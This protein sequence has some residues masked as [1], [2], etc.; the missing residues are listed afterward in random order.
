MSVPGPNT[1]G[2]NPGQNLPLA[3]SI[4][5]DLTAG[6]VVF[7]VAIPLCLGI[8]LA[9]GA[10]LQSGLLS[11]IIGGIVVGA[12]SGSH[13]SVSGPA[14]GLAAIVLAQIQGLGSFQAFLAAVFLAGVLQVVFGLVK[15]GRL[16]NFFPNSVVRGLLAAIGV[17][18]ILKQFPHLIGHDKDFEGEMSFAQPDG[19]NTFSAIGTALRSL[20]PGATLIGLV[21]LALLV[22]WDRT[23]LKKTI[24]PSA[25]VAVLV[26]TVINEILGAT[27]SDWLV[28]GKHL[29]E[30]PVIGKNGVGWSSMF[31]SPDWSRLFDTKV[32]LAALTL[33]IVASLETLLNLEAT[34]KLDPQKRVSP[35]DRELFAQGVG[36]MLAGLAG[37]LPMTSVIIRSSVNVNAGA[38]TRLSAIWHGVL[39]V[40]SI[41]FFAELI[42]RVPLAALA[43]VLVVTGFKLAS[44]KIAMSMWRQGWTQF[45]PF[46]ITVVAIVV[47]DLLVGVLIGLGTAFAFILWRN[48]HGGFQVVEERHVG[49]TLQRIELANQATF[50][51]RAHLAIEFDRFDKGDQVA[52]DAR[53]T[54][55]VDPD[56]LS[57]IREFVHEQAPARGIKVSLLGFK[58]H[59]ELEDV[60]R[61]VDFTTRELQA[62]LTPRRVLELLEEGNQRFVRGQRVKR[63]YDRQVDATSDGQHPMAI[64]LSCI[65]SRAPAEILF[66][67][68]IGDI[69]VV[70]M[71][72]NVASEKTLG[73]MEFACKGVGAKLIVVLGHT[74]CGAIKATCDFAARGVDPVAATGM[75]NLPAITRRIAAA[76][77]TECKAKAPTDALEPAFLDRVAE[78]H[79]LN[80]ME[81][82]E[83][84]SPALREMLEA[85]QIGI[86]GGM[87]DVATGRVRFFG[88]LA[89]APAS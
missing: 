59:Y 88:G 41:V 76:Y 74:R 87:Y 48:L 73:S 83:K 68:G 4:T 37:A 79:V 44:P 81:Y 2:S 60:V 51:N 77:E 17:L 34:D 86:V 62:L 80:T 89:D 85:K 16:S 55:Y 75:T 19:D 61:Y 43:A 6:L 29:V 45:L 67:L 24:V 72:G 33:G 71:A 26:G 82:V 20:L 11:G 57:L 21:S 78:R 69:F 25:L 13:I 18:L 1:P 15:A 39:L 35:P 12:L 5:R 7:L 8:A 46:V 14:A 70:R 64:V 84:F 66:D 28:T 65:D 42:N 49:G 10:P 47:T 22:V 58:D 31:D 23:S 50:I 3:K 54:N 9:S 30:V 52:I 38:R 36:N 53:G 63:D 27:G 40:V 56:V 32:L